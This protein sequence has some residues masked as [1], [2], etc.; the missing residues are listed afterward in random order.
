MT[1][2]N[3]KK[4]LEGLLNEAADAHHTAFIEKDGEG[5]STPDT[6]RTLRMVT[7]A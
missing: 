4:E 7:H 1:N 5:I 2:D 3:L 6:A